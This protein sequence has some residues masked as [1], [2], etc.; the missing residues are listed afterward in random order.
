MSF[1]TEWSSPK[2][3][4]RQ[5][6][7]YRSDEL[8]EVLRVFYAEVRNRQGEDY[9][10][11]TLLGLRN[12]IER[13]LNGP[14]HNKGIQFS[15]NPVFKKSNL[16]L[17]A[18][19]KCLKQQGKENVKHKPPISSQDLQKLKV[20]PTLSPLSPV[21][22]LRN[23]WFHVTLYWCRRGR[24]GQRSL[25]PSSF[26]F[27]IDE[28]GRSY[29]T[30]THDEVTKNHQGGIQD[31]PSYEKNGRM[32][33]MDQV[34]DGYD[35][36]RLYISKLNPNCSAFFQV[37]KRNW[38]DTSEDVW[39]EN[40]PLGVNTLGDMMKKISNEA[41]LSQVYTNHSVRATAITLWAN[42]GLPNRHIMAISGHR[43]EQSLKSYNERPSSD[44]LKLCSDVISHALVPSHTVSMQSYEVEACAS[45]DKHSLEGRSVSS[46]NQQM[47]KYSGLF[48]GCSIGSVQVIFNPRDS[49]SS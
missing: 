7:E 10:K 21:G 31:V 23:V 29:A 42:A 6:H 26:S 22:L 37:P 3:L 36:L 9:S 13:H 38:S 28:E 33:K 41:A 11:S 49:S 2:K 44:Q 17:N 45:G 34:N 4:T 32:Y 25:T 8:D 24:E 30:M 35:A 40:R 12:G 27:E 18:K 46:T 20:S 19:I 39:Y 43:N 16:M 1:S 15:S 5:L 47:N 48:T 14:P